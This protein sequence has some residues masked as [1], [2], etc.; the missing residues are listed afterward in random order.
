MKYTAFAGE[1]TANITFLSIYKYSLLRRNTK[2]SVSTPR[3]PIYKIC[4]TANL[5]FLLDIV[6]IMAP[7]RGGRVCLFKSGCGH[8]TAG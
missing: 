7:M 5:G 4:I 6:L 8:V 1:K 2:N 3:L